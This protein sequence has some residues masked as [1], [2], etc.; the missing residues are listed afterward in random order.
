MRSNDEKN[1]AILPPKDQL[2]IFSTDLADQVLLAGVPP[3]AES[4]RRELHVA[5]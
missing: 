5:R 2:F 4:E 1:G 3:L